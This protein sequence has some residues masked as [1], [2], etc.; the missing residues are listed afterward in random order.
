MLIYTSI[1]HIPNCGE[2]LIIV[3]AFLYQGQNTRHNLYTSDIC[4]DF[5]SNILTSTFHF[6]LF[7]LG[8]KRLHIPLSTTFAWPSGITYQSM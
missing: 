8:T 2:K 6:H 5:F 1:L 3:D 4:T 7:Q